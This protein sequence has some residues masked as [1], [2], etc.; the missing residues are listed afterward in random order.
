M[1]DNIL[2]QVSATHKYEDRF[3]NVADL[4]VDRRVQRTQRKPARIDYLVKNWSDEVAGLAYVSHR[5]D[6]SF[7][8]LDG[9]HR[10]EAQRIRTGN[11]GQLY[12]RVFEGLALA[13]EGAI[14]L[15]LNPGNEPVL[16]DKYKVGVNME[17]IQAV[18]IDQIV[19]SRGWT[20][21]NNVANGHI[22]AVRVLRALD[23]LSLKIEAEPHLIDATLLVLGRAWGND[24]HAVQAA[25]LTGIGRLIAEHG[26]RLDLDTLIE[27]LKGY[28]G[29][30]QG[31]LAQSKLDA[32]IRGVK[33]AMALA[34]L[35]T[36]EYNKGKTRRALPS[37]RHR[38]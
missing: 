26:E 1:T 2:D 12:C 25:M 32:G 5:K 15:F 10:N 21:D 33:H 3:M 17:D 37:W 23:V 11:Q 4:E 20:V 18:R 9:D 35:V 28:K 22:N 6:G 38:T 30:P 8:I 24:R 19:H 13:E 34:D 14:F 7:V 27:K 16:I 29:G 36:I 31:L